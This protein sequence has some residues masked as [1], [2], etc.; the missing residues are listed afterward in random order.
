MKFVFSDKKREIKSRS[1]IMKKSITI[2]TSDES[3]GLFASPDLQSAQSTLLSSLIDNDKINE[4][5]SINDIKDLK[6]TSSNWL[7]LHFNDGHVARQKFN[8]VKEDIKSKTP[9][10]KKD[11]MEDDQPPETATDVDT[12]RVNNFN[13]HERRSFERLLGGIS[14]CRLFNNN[15]LF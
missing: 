8:L 12:E 2:L 9:D 1:F 14:Y 4:N 15:C 13:S 5:Y 11:Q 3:S 7:I 10:K 6:V